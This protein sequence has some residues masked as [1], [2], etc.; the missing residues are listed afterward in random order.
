MTITALAIARLAFGL[1]L[2]TMR[3]ELNLSLAQAGNAGTAVSF[4]YFVLVLPAG[5]MAARYGPR[6]AIIAGL[7]LITISCA[8]LGQV[9][10]YLAVLTVMFFMGCGTALLYTPMIA[11]VVGWFPNR[12]GTVIGVANSGVGIGVLACGFYV[13]WLIT[14]HGGPGYRLAWYSFAL[15]SM[16]LLLLVLALVKNPPGSL[17]NTPGNVES[18]NKDRKEVLQNSGIRAIAVVYG[19]LGVSYIVQSLFMYSYTVDSG[20]DPKRAGAMF[21]TMGLLSIFAGTIWGSLSDYL[22]RGNA[23]MLNFFVTL[24]VTALPV[25][26]PTDT[27]F[28]IHYAVSGLAVGGLF[29]IILAATSECVQARLIPVAVSTVTIALAIGQLIGPIAAGSVIDWSDSY[30]P[31]FMGSSMLMLA[32]VYFSYRLSLVERHR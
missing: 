7:F 27:G 1:L 21:S 24:V 16:L 20:I 32:G 11:L 3:T 5:L 17:T 26:L 4:G 19:I 13:P 8:A 28:I 10:Q 6:V 22:G 9:E 31:A 15:F 25:F 12:R 23:L 14:Q 30:R 2:P 18:R 29:T